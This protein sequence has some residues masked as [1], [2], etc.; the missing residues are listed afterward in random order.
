MG[1]ACPHHSRIDTRI[2][3]EL[4]A[5]WR[6][7]KIGIEPADVVMPA[8]KA[9][10]WKA[11]AYYDPPPKGARVPVMVGHFPCAVFATVA[12]LGRFGPKATSIWPGRSRSTKSKRMRFSFMELG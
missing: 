9:I 8:T 5:F 3:P 12:A 1:S 4:D 10:G 6:P 11:L 7:A 2:A